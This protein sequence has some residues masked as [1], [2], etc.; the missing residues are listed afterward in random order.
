MSDRKMYFGNRNY[1]QWIACPE[2]GSERG[3][4]GVQMS[5]QYLHGGFFN[6]QTFNAAK[7]RTL[8]WA[9]SG[10]D[11]LRPITDYVEGVYGEGAIYWL[12]PFDAD[13]NVLAQSFATPSL[14]G[15]GGVVL[16]GSSK[17]PELVPTGSNSLGYPT[18][19]AVYELD[20]AIDAPFRHWIP[21]PPGYTAWLGAH[22]SATG[23]ATVY[24]G[25]TIGTTP[26][27][28]AP[29]ALLPV[30]TT[31]RFSAD[32]AG[33]AGRNGIELWLGGTGTLVLA[34]VMVQVLP[35]GK[36]P[37]N[38]GFI[39]GQGHAGMSFDGYPTKEAYS[40]ALDLVGVSAN[41]IE[42]EQWR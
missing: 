4:R 40:A 28:G 25:T 29:L 5:G 17:R 14:G 26:A 2:A 19:S 8:S 12:D 22:G 10:R 13:Q 18:E 1:M 27:T 34:G 11:V 37:E 20:T 16:N 32:I 23:T 15:R 33:A 35:N 7:A 24:Y 39:S 31:T 42:T 30:N 6:R 41:F 36:Q 9:L 38:G 3:S 21:V